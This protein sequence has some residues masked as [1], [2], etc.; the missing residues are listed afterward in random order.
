MLLIEINPAANSPRLPRRARAAS[1][2][3][4][5][6]EIPVQLIWVNPPGA[7]ALLYFRGG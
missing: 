7:M 6:R 4:N 2:L 3:G 1:L 5:R